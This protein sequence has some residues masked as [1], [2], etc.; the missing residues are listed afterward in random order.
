MKK[1]LLIVSILHCT[2]FTF[3]QP[4]WV[5]NASKSVFTL[6]TFSADGSLI[7]SSNGFFTGS[8][9]EAISSF[10]PFKGAAR[11]VIIDAAGKWQERPVPW[12]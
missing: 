1:Y 6:K 5:K 10:T 9:G 11:A 8:N 2:L 3:A 12:R 7:A 4:G